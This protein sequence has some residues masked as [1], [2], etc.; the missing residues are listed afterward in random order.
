MFTIPMAMTVQNA[1]RNFW[2]ENRKDA[3]PTTSVKI[4]NEQRGGGQQR[5]LPE[6]R[7][8]DV[9]RE[10]LQPGPALGV[11]EFLLPHGFTISCHDVDTIVHA[12]CQQQDGNRVHR[13]VELKREQAR[14]AI[15]RQDA[16]HR[17][18]EHEERLDDRPTELNEQDDREQEQRSPE[19]ASELPADG[20]G[21]CTI[22]LGE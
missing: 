4:A 13:D 7:D 17:G 1:T 15:G 19:Q 6:C 20:L 16:E 2:D 10:L 21:L 11:L 22:E 14:H 8:A 12:D 3:N 18:P 5:P 9:L